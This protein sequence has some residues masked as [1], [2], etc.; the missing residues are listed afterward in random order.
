[1]KT[2]RLGMQ[3]GASGAFLG[4][5][6]LGNKI[7]IPHSGIP[8]NAVSRGTLIK[9]EPNVPWPFLGHSLAMSECY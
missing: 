6:V 1:M 9:N 3:V 5:L 8:R 2:R 4:I 7:L